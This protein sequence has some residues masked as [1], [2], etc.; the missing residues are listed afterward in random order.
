MSVSIEK[1]TER[2]LTF[3][4][5]EK[6]TS[7]VIYYT[8]NLDRYS[9]SIGGETS[10]FYKWV[11]TPASESF[12]KLMVRCDKWYLCNKLFDKVIDVEASIKA[13]K[14]YIADADLFDMDYE[15]EERESCFN[16]LDRVDVDCQS[17][18]VSR[19]TEILSEYDKDDSE[20]EYTIYGLIEKTYKHWDE[21]AIDL[22]CEFIKPE[23]RKEMAENG[24]Q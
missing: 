10:G 14:D 4:L 19:V 5:H 23:L 8:L 24:N 12:L 6:E 9:L 20:T 17:C 7:A 11:E 13:V 2:I 21:R 15:A 1:Q 18:F 3:R 22:F 16:D